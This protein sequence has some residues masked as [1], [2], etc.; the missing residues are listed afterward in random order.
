M[1]NNKRAECVP[2]GQTTARKLTCRACGKTVP[3]SKAHL[4]R[5]PDQKGG[6]FPLWKQA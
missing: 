3:E 5:C 1:E 6:M 4:H 2:V